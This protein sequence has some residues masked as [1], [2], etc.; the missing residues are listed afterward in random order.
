MGSLRGESLKA[1]GVGKTG[2][3]ALDGLGQGSRRS[4]L[5]SMTDR[6]VFTGELEGL[7]DLNDERSAR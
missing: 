5:N 4:N 7:T 1:R 2:R 3:K 6:N